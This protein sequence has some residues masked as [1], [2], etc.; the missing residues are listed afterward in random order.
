V[1]L[2]AARA[3]TAV[4]GRGWR[5]TIATAVVLGL[6]CGLTA[7]ALLGDKKLGSWS[8]ATFEADARAVGYDLR[9]SD[10]YVHEEVDLVGPAFDWYRDVP[11]FTVTAKNPVP[12]GS[13]PT[14]LL[15]GFL[16]QPPSWIQFVGA[17]PTRPVRVVMFGRALAF[18]P[19]NQHYF[20]PG[21]VRLPR[22]GPWWQFGLT[23]P[24]EPSRVYRLYRITAPRER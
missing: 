1:A 24:V 11:P 21:R 5:A 22:V 9:K 23:A 10:V 2:A 20:A 15:V 18:E 17:M 19:F 14:L 6:L 13:K 8:P 3:I 4:I 7:L 12:S 16:P